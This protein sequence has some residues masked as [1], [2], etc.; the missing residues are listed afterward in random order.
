MQTK[1]ETEKKEKEIALLQKDRAEKETQIKQS[2]LR[3][4]NLAMVLLG[5]LVLAGVAITFFSQRSR[6]TKIVAR[7]NDQIHNQQ[8]NELLKDQELKSLDAMLEGQEIERKRMAEDLHDRLGST[9]SA[10]KLHFEAT[11]GNE[12]NQENKAIELLDKAIADTRE[13]AHN[14]LSGVLSKFGLVAALNDLKDTVESTNAIAI[15]IRTKQFDGRLE[16]DQEIN[17][18]RIVQEAVSNVLKHAK[19]TQVTISILKENQYLELVVNDNG[20]GLQ[21]ESNKGVGLKNMAARAAKIDGKFHISSRPDKGTKLS[22]M[23]LT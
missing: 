8:I 6:M 3:A 9:L 16:P 4:K 21:N 19:A 1:Y 10:A 11:L 20:I 17:L 22:I 14:I 15:N 7:K 18:Y 5:A 23:L 12:N 2:S 13:I